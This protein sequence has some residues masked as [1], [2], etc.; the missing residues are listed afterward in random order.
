MVI[1]S[2]KIL[3]SINDIANT[4]QQRFSGRYAYNLFDFG[5]KQSLFVEKSWFVAI[6]VTR[7]ENRMIIERTPKPSVILVICFL[8]DLIVTGSGNVLDRLFPFYSERKKLEQELG[9]FLEQE[10]Q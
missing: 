2:S 10:Y 8:L 4:L 5:N 7:E 9:T 3:P 1:N 6:Q